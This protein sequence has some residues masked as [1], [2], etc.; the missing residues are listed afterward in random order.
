MRLRFVCSS[1]VVIAV[2]L[3]S[4]LSAQAEES[5]NHVTLSVGAGF[6]TSTGAIAS[7]IDQGGNLE[8]NGGYFFSRRFGITGN[9]M[10]SNLGVTRATLADL[11]EPDGKAHVYALTADP[12]I[13]LPLGKRFTVYALAGGGYVRRNVEFTMPI[14]GTVVHKN[15]HVVPVTTSMVMSSIVE[16]SPGFDVGGG[17]NMPSLWSGA[18]FFVEARYFKG[19]TSDNTSA[20]AVVPITF[21]IRW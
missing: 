9:F 15:S 20:T 8:L 7:D 18:K 6:T 12:T 13:R 11:N 10:F 21:G 14:N 2:T 17:L 1:V 16:N 3:P 19:F 4:L 5:F